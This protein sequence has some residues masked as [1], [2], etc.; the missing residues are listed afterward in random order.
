LPPALVPFP[1]KSLNKCATEVTTAH[2]LPPLPTILL[3]W[4]LT[5][6]LFLA[7]ALLEIEPEHALGGEEEEEDTGGKTGG[8]SKFVLAFAPL[9]LLAAES[10]AR[11]ASSAVSNVPSQWRHLPIRSL[12]SA[13]HL[14]HGL[15]LTPL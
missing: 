4:L 3:L 6:V 9:S 2:F 8:I 14:P 10:Y 1:S 15:F 13:D 12:I 7:S 5:L 11:A